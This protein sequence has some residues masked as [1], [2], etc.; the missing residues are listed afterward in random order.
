MEQEI[1]DKPFTEKEQKAFSEI[2]KPTPLNEF[3]QG[4]QDCKDG[5]EPQSQSEDYLRGYGFQ[6]EIEQAQSA[7]SFN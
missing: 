5:C 3:I 1:L 2:F 6:Y 7:G 4:Q